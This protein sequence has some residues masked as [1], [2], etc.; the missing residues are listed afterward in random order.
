MDPFEAKVTYFAI[1]VLLI[2]STIILVWAYH[3][4]AARRIIRK[5]LKEYPERL[6]EL[7]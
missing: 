7:L 2:N 1:G 6:K 4:W 3:L 5:Q